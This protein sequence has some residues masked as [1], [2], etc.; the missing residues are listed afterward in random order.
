M[1]GGR[2]YRRRCPEGTLSLSP[3]L[4]GT[5]YP[6]LVGE[7]RATLNR[8]ESAPRHTHCL[9]I[10]VSVPYR[11]WRTLI[12]RGLI[13]PCSGLTI[14]HIPTTQG[15]SYLA[16]LGWMIVSRWHTVRMRKIP[17]ENR[18]NA[19]PEILPPANVPDIR[20][21]TDAHG[22]PESRSHGIPDSK[23]ILLASFHGQVSVRFR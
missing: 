1:L 12:V 2:V 9:M 23:K 11:N 3:G 6:G 15:S 10:P 13:Q 21:S 20:R 17:R 4:R 7:K 14:D 5:S 19:V 16:T 22:S 8:V 18:P